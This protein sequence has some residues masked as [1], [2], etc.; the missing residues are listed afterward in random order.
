MVVDPKTLTT[1]PAQQ[2]TESAF[3]RACRLAPNKYTPI[4]L[5]RQA[6]RFLPEYREI[7]S[8]LG[9]LE[10]CKNP[11]V[12]AEVTVMA[13]EKLGVDAAIIFADILLV[14]EPMGIGLSFSEGDGPLIA[15]PI[16][17]ARDIERLSQ[18]DPQF[19]LSFVYEAIRLARRNLKA[20]IPLIGFA[21]APFTLASYLIEGGASKQFEKT[22]CFMYSEPQAWER[23]MTLLV[24]VTVGHLR[25]QIKAGAQ[26]LQIFDSWVGCL[27]VDDYKNQ[28][29][30]HVQA[31]IAQLKDSVPIIYFGTGSAALLP[32]ICQ[33]GA[34]IIG[35]DWR[36]DLA[37]EWSKMG[38]ETAI[39]GNLDPCV[40][41]CGREQ[42]VAK[43]DSI[44]AA[45]QSRPGHIFNLGHGVLPQTP[46][47]SVRFLVETVH[48]LSNR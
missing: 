5:M 34:Q 40:L 2:A 16:R 29:L 19:H 30:P 38:Y 21:G 12:A 10:L 14:L 24:Q 1:D 31:I 27:S 11:E 23:L 48:E 45:A 8:K 28:V 9:F 22:K 32:S 33:T 41:L 4:W 15:S 7:R 46:V 3:L 39:Q 35:L 18:V 43:V 17:A 36:V 47:D 25:E 26:T 44:L 37:A 20:N 42:I 13:V 6:G